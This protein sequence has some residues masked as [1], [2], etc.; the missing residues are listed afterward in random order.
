MIDGMFVIIND[1]VTLIYKML[2]DLPFSDGSRGLISIWEL[3]RCEIL[4]EG[5]ETGF[6]PSFIAF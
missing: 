4:L 5:A 2:G 1:V 6:L 3:N